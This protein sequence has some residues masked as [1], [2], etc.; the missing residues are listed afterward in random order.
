MHRRIDIVLGNREVCFLLTSYIE[1]KGRLLLMDVRVV[2]TTL[3]LEVDGLYPH[4]EI[5]SRAH[6]CEE[7]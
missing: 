6:P 1:R 3:A 5:N 7:V 2:L 4:W